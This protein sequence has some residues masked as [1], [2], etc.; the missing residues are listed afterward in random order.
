MSLT[1]IA[2]AAGPVN[3]VMP[4]T[5]WRDCSRHRFAYVLIRIEQFSG[6]AVTMKVQSC[7]TLSTDDTAWADCTT[8]ASIAGA[9]QVMLKVL[10]NTTDT[11]SGFVRIAVTPPASGTTTLTL[12]A[13][14]LL[15]GA[16][17]AVNLV[18][19]DN[20]YIQLG[21]NE[22]IA[23]PAAA[24]LDA[25][26]Y[27]DVFLLAE[28]EPQGSSLGGDFRLNL[29]TAPAASAL[30]SS[31]WANVDFGDGAATANKF[32]LDGRLGVSTNPPM[33]VL[34]LVFESRNGRAVEG[35]LSVYALLRA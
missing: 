8:S 31:A 26:A 34:R 17:D 33:G 15:K 3:W 13:D 20:Q 11:I 16:T 14:L 32:Q 27:R 6:N 28:F 21:V 35:R 22:S 29:E 12:R 23:M 5:Y 19:V 4:A 1:S 25:S 30:A 18:W 10:P 24:W 7:P 2:V 9:G